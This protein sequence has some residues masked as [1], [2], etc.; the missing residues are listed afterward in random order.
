MQ[1]TQ[2]ERSIARRGGKDISERG[3]WFLDFDIVR[4]NHTFINLYLAKESETTTRNVTR[5]LGGSPS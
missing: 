4:K 1:R 3:R 2:G 5:V